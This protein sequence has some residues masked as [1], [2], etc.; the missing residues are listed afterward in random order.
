MLA[1][2]E[3][4]MPEGVHWTHPN[5]GMF[6]WLTV[7]EHIDTAD[8]LAIAAD[9]QVVFVPGATFH[10][11]GGGTNTMRLNFSHSA[12]ERITEGIGRLAAAVREMI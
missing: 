6:I 2:L 12:P 9:Q 7:P 11:N 4:F 5:G 3:R 8:L 1:A 10:A